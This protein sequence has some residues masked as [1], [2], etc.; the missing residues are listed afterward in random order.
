[1]ADDAATECEPSCCHSIK[2]VPG[3]ELLADLL[4]CK[5]AAG[6]KVTLITSFGPAKDRGHKPTFN[7]DV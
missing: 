5:K 4:T 6:L 2:A 7:P 1:M 3:R